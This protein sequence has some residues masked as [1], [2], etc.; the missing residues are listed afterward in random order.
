MKFFNG[1]KPG[2]CV[3]EC[4]S[5]VVTCFNYG[6]PIISIHNIRSPT[7]CEIVENCS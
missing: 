4:K 1:G 2:H 3:A 5:V 6:N 7:N